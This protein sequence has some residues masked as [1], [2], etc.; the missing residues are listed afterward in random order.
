MSGLSLDNTDCDAGVDAISLPF[1]DAPIARVL[2]ILSAQPIDPWKSFRE[3]EAAIDVMEYLD[4]P[5][6]LSV[7]RASC[8]TPIFCAEPIRL[9]GLAARFG[10]EEVLHHAAELTLNLNL[11]P[12]ADDAASKIEEQLMRLPAPALY[13]LIKLHRRRRDKFRALIY[14]VD[15]F[16]V[17]NAVHINC[18]CGTEINNSFWREL[19]SRLVWELDQNPSGRTILAPEMEEMDESARCWKAKCSR[20]SSLYYNRLGTSKNIRMCVEKLPKIL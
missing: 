4:T 15:T 17:G 1:E 6:P 16:S 3:L 2:L 13:R 18:S 8:F 5:G 12:S 20:C 9:Y 11:F 7:V 19:R 14:S 10:W